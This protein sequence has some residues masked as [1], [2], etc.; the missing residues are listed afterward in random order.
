MTIDLWMLVW[1]VLLTFAQVVVAAIGAASQVGLATL[2]GNREAMPE[3]DGWA[4]RALRAH[5][6]M[7]ESLPVFAAL[8]LVAHVS[9]MA[10]EQTALGAQVFVV[11]R[12]VHAVVYL[13]GIP[14][15]RTLVFAVSV[16]GL[17]MILLP[18]FGTAG[19][20]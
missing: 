3:L 17:V 12:L 4:G 9:G 18:L 15:L 5:R 19:T 14:W 7:L 13:F 20:V 1:A 10:D 2:A 6:N 16:V 11:A 8:V